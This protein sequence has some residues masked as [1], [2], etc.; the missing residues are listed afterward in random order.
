MVLLALVLTPVHAQDYTHTV[1]GIVTE[2]TFYSPEIVRVTKYQASDALGK[3]DPK[4][5][6]TMAPQQVNPT[7]INGGNVDTLAT[8]K[9][10]VTIA[11][12]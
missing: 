9:V 2:I 1:N 7:I 10:V 11:S 4:L 5:V 6:V 8:E 3:S 12:P